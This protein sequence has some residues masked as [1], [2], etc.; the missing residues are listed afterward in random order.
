LLGIEKVSDQTAAQITFLRQQ[1]AWIFSS[2]A[3]ETA[4]SL[5]SLVKT[6]H[7]DA[8]GASLEN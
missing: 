8:Y 5:L 3:G 1:K 6:A 7:V 2:Q 4:M